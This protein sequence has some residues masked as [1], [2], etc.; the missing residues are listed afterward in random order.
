[1]NEREQFKILLEFINEIINDNYSFKPD[2]DVF[3]DEY[4]EMYESILKLRNKI[5]RYI[6]EVQVASSQVTSATDELSSILVENNIVTQQL[7][8]KAKEMQQLNVNGQDAIL[9]AMSE[10]KDIANILNEVKETSNQVKYSSM[11]SKEVL[12][13][14]MGEILE[15]VH[16]VESIKESSQ[17]TAEYI[18]RLKGSTDKIGDIVTSVKNIAM[19]T[20]IIALNATIESA[21]AGTAGRGFAVLADEIRRLAEQSKRA[22]DEISSIIKQ[23]FD[24]MINLD[25]QIQENVENVATSVNCSK[26]VELSLSRIEQTYMDIQA[27]VQT[28]TEAIEEEAK[29]SERIS[30][31]VQD[32]E[33]ISKEVTDGFRHVYEAVYK[34]KN[35]SESIGGLGKCLLSSSNSLSI[36]VEKANINLLN[37]N[38]KKFSDLADNVVGILK[39][40]LLSLEDIVSMAPEKHKKLLDNC[41]SKHDIIE[42]IWSNNE[43]GQFIYS[44]PPAGIA[45]AKVREWFQ[46]SM[47]GR[48][49]LSDIYISAI[50]KNPCVTVSLPIKDNSGNI[51]GVLGA[52]LKLNLEL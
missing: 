32:V 9:L 40:E 23:I 6:F 43:K 16:S 24:G 3:Q 15:I 22:V 17:N 36:L 34:Q 38:S 10:I 7:N 47:K 13:E 35:I 31:K 26:N 20:E 12:D 5:C 28:I 46:L 29:L 51:I 39:R 8:E 19:Q 27:M 44:N 33:D 48:S 14:S 45:N 1:M 4:K 42:A 41:M 21:R 52:D 18:N 37:D 11:Q 49:Y 2:K 50:T 30:Y 25:T